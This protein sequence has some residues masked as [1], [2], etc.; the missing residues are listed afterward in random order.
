M[1]PSKL[2][3]GKINK[4]LLDTKNEH[5]LKEIT[6]NQWKNTSQVTNWF[7]NIKN[8]ITLSFMNFDVESF[9]PSI[10]ID[11]FTDAINY[12]KT[13]TSIDDDQLSTIMQSRKT[14]LFNNNEP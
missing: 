1:N 12:A 9:Y 11:L 3:I 6:V 13:I 14:L 2:N 10:S 7:N 4:S 5:I 8:K